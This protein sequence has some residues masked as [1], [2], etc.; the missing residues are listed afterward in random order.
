MSLPETPSAYS[1]YPIHSS[2][3]TGNVIS[4]CPIPPPTISAAQLSLVLSHELKTPLTGIMSLAQVLQHPT[5][6]Q[7]TQQHRYADLLYRKSQQLLVVVN[8]LLDLTQLCTQ[9]FVLQVH[10]VDLTKILAVAL[11]TAQR[12][13]GLA[14]VP[15]PEVTQARNTAEYWLAGD[16]A[17]L[18]Q[19]FTHL[20]CFLL[21]PDTRQPAL[22]LSLHP[23]ADGLTLTFGMTPLRLSET[24]Q[25]ELLN[26]C[27]E[28]DVNVLGC[29]SAVLQFVF[30]R[31][32]ALLQGGEINWR[33]RAR[34]GLVL[35]VTLPRDLTGALSPGQRLQT[36]ATDPTQSA[37]PLGIHR[38]LTLLHLEDRT[39][40]TAPA[41][42]T[43]ELL[44]LLS[45]HYGCSILSVNDLK[46]AELLAQIWQAK[47]MICLETVPNWLHQAS[48]PSSITEL[49]LFVL[50]GT[51]AETLSAVT[52]RPWLVYPVSATGMSLQESA[53]HLYQQLV[54]ASQGIH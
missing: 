41:P 12:I 31:Y 19:L 26:A 18:T 22:S 14:A 50:G 27:R 13:A 46:Q 51:E 30:A 43:L 25:S 23:H 32:L 7:P 6:P 49:P 21:R 5:S 33:T 3:K 37:G 15:L 54:D 53:A 28:R 11:R 24:E 47:V 9:H 17:R 44:A 48:A 39:S 20:L 40:S 38:S 34:N 16:E 1:P 52:H 29:S 45:N 8:D 4:L 36:D 2:E 35:T 42:Q 10:P